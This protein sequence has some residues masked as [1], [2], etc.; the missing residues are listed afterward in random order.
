MS[1]Y[2]CDGLKEVTIFNG[3]ARLEFHRLQTAERGH[4]REVQAISEFIVALPTQG[5]IQAL[6]VL[7]KVREQLI[8][9]GLLKPGGGSETPPPEPVKSPNFS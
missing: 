4:N 8:R 7:E 9:D 5:F 2:F 6:S 1:T 3:V